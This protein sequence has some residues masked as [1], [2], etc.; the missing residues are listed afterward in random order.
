MA[1]RRALPAGIVEADDRDVAW[2][3]ETE[4]A[5]GANHAERHHVARREHRGRTFVRAEQNEAL[6]VAALGVEVPFTHVVGTFRE[7]ESRELVAIAP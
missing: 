3:R 2:N 4:L 6:P 5:G 7:T 1:G